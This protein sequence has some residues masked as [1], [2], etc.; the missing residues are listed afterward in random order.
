MSTAAIQRQ[1]DEVIAANYDL[2]P[3]E[4]TN[5]M[6]DVALEHV[7]RTPLLDITF[8]PLQALDLGMGT[9]LFLEKL[10][11]VAARGVRPFGLDLSPRMVDFAKRR[12]P[13]LQAV[14][15]DAAE[16][17]RHFIGENFDFIST[18]FVTGF[19]PIEHLAPRIFKKLK[20]GGY[21]SFLG[22]VSSA[23][24]QLQKK[25]N[26]KLL[27]F[28]ARGRKIKA[29]DLLTPRN[30]DAVSDCFRSHGFDVC[31]LE[32][33][34][35]ALHFA[36]FDSFM[37]FGYHG[38]WLTPF[39]EAVGLQNAKPWLKTVLNMLVFPLNDEHHVA[40][41]LARRPNS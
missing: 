33:A 7:L 28:V 10:R 12:L 3:Q 15:D 2:D 40:V 39:I 16:I 18:H 6:L 21:W 17:D 37:E 29:D 8:E 24:P 30:G 22:A 31:S 25:G 9:G 36:D 38:G 35:P 23:Y 20:P 26:S 19:V 41:G 13:D 27:R 32:V 1:Y 11:Q 4:L 5:R 34:T 14:I